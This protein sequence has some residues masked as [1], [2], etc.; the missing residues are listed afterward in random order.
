MLGTDP[1]SARAALKRFN[2]GID[3]AENGVALPKAFHKA[4]T[5][6]YYRMVNREAT[7]WTTRQEAINGLN[8]IA[9]DLMKESGKLK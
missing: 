7:K 3:A 9:R 5:D 2:I 4:L 1:F 8:K 6:E